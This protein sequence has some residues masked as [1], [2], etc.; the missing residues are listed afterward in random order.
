MTTRAD[1]LRKLIDRFDGKGYRAYK[2]IGG[3][4]RFD[5]FTLFI[6]HIQGDPYAAPSRIR[7]RVAQDIACIPETLF[8]TPVRRIATE[9]YFARMTST[10]IA[11]IARGDRGTGHSGVISIDA[12][13]QSVLARSAV[14]INDRWIEARLRVGLPAS[15]RTILG[16][17]AIAMFC[18]ELPEIVRRGLLW[19]GT[20]DGL[21]AEHF[22]GVIENHAAL[23]AQLGERDLVA[24]IADGASLPRESGASDRPL[25]DARSIAF[26]SCAPYTVTLTLPHRHDGSRVVDSISGLGIPAGVTLIVGGGYHGK[27][28]LLRALERGV[29]PHVPGDGR[30][31]VACDSRAIKIRAEDRRRVEKVDISAFIT[32]LPLGRSTRVF[33]SDDASGSTSQAAN[34]A[35]AIEAGATVLLIDEDSSATNFMV[36][37]ARMQ[38]LVTKDS[39]PITPLLDRVRELYDRFGVSSILVMGG[40]GDYFDVADHVIMMKDYQPRDATSD[41]SRIA[42]EYPTGRRPENDTAMGPIPSRTPDLGS[43]DTSR[44]ADATGV[45]AVRFGRWTVDLRGVDQLVDP[46]QTR[47]VARAVAVA[48][49]RWPNADLSVAE[50][51]DRLDV[52]FDEEGLD[53]LNPYGHSDQHPGEFARPRRLEVAAALNRLRSLRVKVD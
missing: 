46:S 34:I 29:Y 17:D 30:E 23:C 50:I 31:M 11:H 53:V 13:E 18:E 20:E 40:C 27:S 49:E 14:V 22:V 24:F 21:E 33:S 43:I 8:D 52:M 6:D 36:R 19:P 16:D 1:V 28:T 25:D 26:S 44:G 41:A 35:E 10:A 9:D 15:G 47:A 37:D 48:R 12:G 7:A 51:L 42:L 45:D 3:E 39:E 5:Q 32:D 4:Y 2:Q 38:A